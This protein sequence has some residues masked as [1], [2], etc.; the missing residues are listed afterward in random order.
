MENSVEKQMQKLSIKQTQSHE[1]RWA[2]FSQFFTKKSN[3]LLIATVVAPTLISTLYYGFVASDVYVS[4]SSFV[5]RSPRNQGSLSGLGALLQGAGFSRAQDD[6]YSVHEFMR[7]RDALQGLSASLPLKQEYSSSSVDI[8]SRYNLFGKDTFE[9]FYRYF[10]NMVSIELDNTTSIS[11]LRTKA[12]TPQTA[13]QLNLTLLDSAETLINQ[14]NDRARKDLVSFAEQQLKEA[15]DNVKATADRLNAYRVKY[16]VFDL[17]RQTKVQLQVI[18]KLQDELITIKTQYA[19]VQAVTPKNPQLPSLV[20]RERSIR[21][22][23]NNELNRLSGVGDSS[24]A[25]KAAEFEKLTLESELAEKQFSGALASLESS[26]IEMLKKQ[27][28]L[29]RISQPN[30][31]DLALEPQRIKNILITLI[32]GLIVYGILKLLISSVN[33]HQD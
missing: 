13:Q 25:T 24:F 23:I 1:K 8:A 29:E 22:E 21:A 10:L 5:V 7:S 26:K 6:I 14:L 9:G 30:K 12:Y 28:Y 17:Q 15:S 31:P 11:T 27:L 4:E 2:K 33:E 32:L 18:S 16:G 19:Q 20:A 3:R